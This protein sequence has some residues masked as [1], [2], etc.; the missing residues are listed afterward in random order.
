[1][2]RPKAVHYCAL[3]STLYETDG[4]AWAEEQITKLRALAELRLNL[5]LDVGHL[6]EELEGM[7][8]SDREAVASFARLIVLHLLLLRHAGL[9]EPEA[10]WRAEL[11][12]FRVQLRRRLKGVL[13][14]YLEGELD[15][16][17]A[18]AVEIAHEKISAELPATRPGEITVD[19]LIE[20]GW[21]LP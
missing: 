6:I 11:A 3:M 16:V 13:V 14:P 15:R 5:D 7:A 1:M 10:H 9:V 12:A 20:P 4:V 19:R 21:L 18:E 17:W 8:R 2:A